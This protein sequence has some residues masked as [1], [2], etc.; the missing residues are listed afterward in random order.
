M[1]GVIAE[2]H[3]LLQTYV[4]VFSKIS[5]MEFSD[6]PVP[7][8]WS[9]KEIVGHL[10]D[11]AQNNLRR[12]IA[13]QTEKNPHIVYDQDHWVASN[14]YQN[15]DAEEVIMLWKLMNERICVVLKNMNPENYERT[16]NTGIEKISLKTIAWLAEDY[17]KH[18]KH[19]INQVLPG[20]F[21]ITYP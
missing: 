1:K 11:S 16:V 20:S 14:D 4:P 9:K 12:F 7:G 19:H 2:L 3:Q 15:M 10:I 18:L 8:K 17:V 6:K 13:V 21:N 5:M